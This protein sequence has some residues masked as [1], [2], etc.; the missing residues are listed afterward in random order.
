MKVLVVHDR[1]EIKDEI[2]N[3]LNDEQIE[4]GDLD[5]AIDVVGAREKL[6]INI[7]DLLIIDLTLPHHS[8]DFNPGYEQTDLLLNELFNYG[9]LN[10]PGDIIGITKD[11]AALDRVANS[12][13]A[14]MMAAIEEDGDGAWRRQLRDK[15]NYV[16]RIARSR[17]L[18]SNQHYIYDVLVMTALDEE[19]APLAEHYEF[20]DVTYFEGAMEFGFTDKFG[21]VRKGIAFSVGK[22]GQPSAASWTQS[23]ITFFRPK[24]A[25]MCGI[26]GGIDDKVGI[27]DIIFFE[28]AYAW[29]YGKWVEKKKFYGLGGTSSVFRSRPDPIGLEGTR[30]EKLARSYVASDFHKQP[31]FLQML[32]E[33]SLGKINDVNMH[34]KPAASGSA[35]IANDEVIEKVVGL[36]DSI[37]A[38]DMES[39]GFYHAA[40][41]TQVCKPEFLCVKSV[42]DYCSTS[43]NDDFHPLCSEISAS[44]VADIIE[45][46]W[47]F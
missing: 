11:L 4:G 28:A 39:Y 22:S 16:K 47:D 36:N 27:G 1:D 29:D 26:C 25:L 2:C 15:I 19:M 46:K 40:L 37:R 42:S 32:K 21:D 17:Q 45:N 18:S 41:K 3:L 30:T 13:L 9:N 33:K 6:R 24:L 35:V 8:G 34:F 31:K 5:C 10:S 20:S 43:K 7:Y 14:H 23:L 44:L 12:I 38:V